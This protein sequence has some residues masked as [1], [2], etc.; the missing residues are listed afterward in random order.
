M[1]QKV[2]QEG[3][4]VYICLRKIEGRKCLSC[5]VPVTDHVIPQIFP[6]LFDSGQPAIDT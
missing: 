2:V 6:A 3:G 4:E 1:V 5:Q